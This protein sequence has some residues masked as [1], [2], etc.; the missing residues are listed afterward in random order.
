[1]LPSKVSR[2]VWPQLCRS[3]PTME[4][5]PTLGSSATSGGTSFL[6]PH[7]AYRLGTTWVAANHSTLAEEAVRG[8][9]GG[10]RGVAGCAGDRVAGQ[11]W[12]SHRMMGRW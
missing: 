11:Q 12:R 10:W 8:Y 6:A 5:H 1:M 3:T 2:L 4:R 9:E 7:H